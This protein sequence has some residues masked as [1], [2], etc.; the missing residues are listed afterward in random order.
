MAAAPP[1]SGPPRKT[2][3]QSYFALN[4]RHRLYIGLAGV[5]VSLAGIAAAD[6]LERNSDM[7]VKGQVD[8]IVGA[9]SR[10]SP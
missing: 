6:Y 3:L 8:A 5:G 1:P 4:P 7:A 2:F 9:A 10:P